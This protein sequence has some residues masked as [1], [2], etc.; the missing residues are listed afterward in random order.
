MKSNTFRYKISVS[1]YQCYHFFLSQVNL[2]KLKL[3]TSKVNE[4]CSEHIRPTSHVDSD[5]TF[6]IPR[7]ESSFPLNLRKTAKEEL[8]QYEIELKIMK[9]G[10]IK[11]VGA[12]NICL[13][14]VKSHQPHKTKLRELGSPLK[15]I[16]AI[17]VKYAVFEGNPDT[18]VQNTNHNQVS[19]PHTTQTVQVQSVAQP[20]EPAQPVQPEQTAQRVQKGTILNSNG[21]ISNGSKEP[22][23]LKTFNNLAEKCR[24]NFRKNSCVIVLG[25]TGEGKTT[26]VNL[27]TGNTAKTGDESHG[28]TLKNKWYPNILHGDGDDGAVGYPD[29]LDT[30]GLDESGADLTDG[31][32]VKSYLWDLLSK[33]IE[34]VHAVIWCI[35]PKQRVS[36]SMP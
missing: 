31:E 22:I 7:E 25:T 1:Y 32:L 24:P 30:V 20:V 4:E 18:H 16:Q 8:E 36:I 23:K 28:V 14:D 6:I 2:N 5:I 27:Y 10:K 9:N 3:K 33:N 26:T 13:S 21:N 17:N 19:E 15:S 12:F 11:V 34:W 35:S 29:W